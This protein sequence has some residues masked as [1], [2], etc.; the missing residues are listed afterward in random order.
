[1]AICGFPCEMGQD[2]VMKHPIETMIILI[3]IYDFSNNLI[4]VIVTL[5]RGHLKPK[6]DRVYK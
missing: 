6:K 4:F 5:G 2:F 3:S 1:M